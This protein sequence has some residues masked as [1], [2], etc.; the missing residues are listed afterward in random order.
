[1]QATEYAAQGL[2][3]VKD[4]LNGGLDR[5]RE[6]IESYL[7]EPDSALPLQR[8]V[9]ELHQ[10]RGTLRMVQCD[11]AALLAEEMKAAVQDFFAQSA[12][13]PEAAFEAVLGAV[14]Q[15]S[16]YFD[17]LES[18]ESD[19]GLI[20][21]P[22]INELRVARGTS[23]VS[24]SAL[25]A[26]YAAQ[27]APAMA[28]V[29]LSDRDPQGGQ[30]VA[31][32]RV[33]AFNAALLPV[34]R[35]QSVHG[36]I[37]TLSNICEEMV[38]AASLPRGRQLFLVCGGLL[39][40]LRAD[41]LDL[42]NDVKRL[43]GRIGQQLKTIAEA[44]DRVMGEI[45]ETLLYSVVYYIGRATSDG[46]KVRALRDA[47]DLETLLPD[48]AELERLR[49][50]MRG[51]N[52][53]LVQRL[54]TEIKDDIELVKNSIDLVVRAGDKADVD[55]EEAVAVAER[56]SDT[57]GML[58]MDALRRVVVNQTQSIATLIN[59]GERD[60]D[61]WMDVAM[62]L[63][64]V[65]QS[66]DK[67]LFQHMYSGGEPEELETSRPV[68][69][70]STGTAA[71]YHEALANLS[72]LKMV[73]PSYISDG[74]NEALS[75]A[76][77]LVRQ[78]E[79]GLQ[80]LGED[81]A[82][83][84]LGGLR[85]FL[86]SSGMQAVRDNQGL[87]LVLADAI[88]SFEYYIEALQSD[89]A[90][91]K[92]FHNSA[93]DC[94]AELTR[95]AGE[96][97]PVIDDGAEAKAAAESASPA[98]AAPPDDVDPE[99]REIFIEEA[100]EV[101]ETLEE[102][103]PLWSKKPE[104]AVRLT[105]IR[106]GFHTLKGSGRMVGAQGIGEFAWSVEYL[107]NRCLEGAREIDEPVT[108]LVAD[109]VALLPDL[110]EDFSAGRGS[111]GIADIMR[112]ADGLSG[113]EP[114]EAAAASPAEPEAPVDDKAA[115]ADQPTTGEPDD[116]LLEIFRADAVRHVET[117]R[118][119]A[120]QAVPGSVSAEVA[121]ALHTLKGSA[122]AVGAE[123]FASLAGELE[124]F[125]DVS[126][127]TG[128]AVSD[129]ARAVLGQAC[130]LFSGSIQ[131]EGD[132]LQD[133]PP[134]D[135]DALGSRV[136]AL[137]EPLEQAAAEDGDHE[138]MLVFTEE[139]CDIVDAMDTAIGQW[140]AAP[141]SDDVPRQM[142]VHTHKLKGSAHTAEADAMA[143][144]AE[145]LEDHAS[146]FAG[147]HRQAT[148]FDIDRVAQVVEGLYGML[149][150]YRTG[151]GPSDPLSLIALLQYPEPEQPAA[152]A[153]EDTTEPADLV[154]DAPDD[155][156][157]APTVADDEPVDP[158]LVEIFV[159]EATDL[160]ELMEGQL[161]AWTANPEDD[162]PR[163]ELMRLLHTLKGSARMAQVV[164]MGDLAHDMETWIGDA[165]TPAQ[166]SDD[167]LATRIRNA[168]DQM[169]EQ[170]DLVQAGQAESAAA[171]PPAADESRVEAEDAA[172][173]EKPADV[174]TEGAQTQ[175]AAPRPMR[176]GPVPTEFDARLFWED[177]T[178][179]AESG[180]SQET[181]RVAVEQL[182]NMLNQ[183][184]EISIFRTRLEQQNTNIQQHL[185][186][187]SQTAMRLR[188]QL[189]KLDLETEAQILA[190]Q[191]ALVDRYKDDFDPLEMD[192]YSTLNE[193][194]R[195]LAEG[196]T[197]LMSIHGSMST[198]AETGESLLVHQ[199]RVNTSL[200]QAL[201]STLMVP[202]SRQ[203]QRLERILR[204]TS[205]EYGRKA[206]IDFSG[207]EAELDRNV[208][209]RMV[210]P[211][212]H[213]LRNAVIHG[214]EAPAERKAAGKP[215]TGHIQVRLYREGT[216]LVIELADDGRGLDTGRIREKA[217]E[218]GML[219]ANSQVDDTSLASLIFEP[220]FSTADKLTQAAGRGVG[221]DV[222]NAEIKQ[223]GGS[224][225]VDSRPGKGASFSIRLPLTLAISQALLVRVGRED[226]AIPL[227][228]IEG[229]TRVPRASMAEHLTA[230]KPSFE[231]GG[232]TYLMRNLG[233][234]LNVQSSDMEE[235]EGPRNLPVLLVRIGE[236]RS[237][238]VVDSMFGSREVVVKSLG[239]QVSTVR[240]ISG[241]TIM[242]DGQVVLILDIT[243]LMQ[244]QARRAMSA[245]Q[246]DAA[247]PRAP[248]QV[249]DSP[250]AMVVDDSIT[251]RRVSERFLTRN[252]FRVMT[253]KDGMD[254]LAKLQSMVPD[255]M[256]LDIE[257]PRIDGFELATYMR[258]S[259]TLRDTPIVMITS[260][261]GDK[262][263]RRAEEIGVDRFLTK[264]YQEQD[265]LDNIRSV[266]D[267]RSEAAS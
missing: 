61:A 147:G 81:D 153:T 254:A 64:R 132:G 13:A 48:Q 148:E 118:A 91:P 122:R 222:V 2:H 54:S 232:Q 86:A 32:E 168:A 233:G 190:R 42:D 165:Q 243:A 174:S 146:L 189:R 151:S 216:Q 111:N 191:E 207:V 201:M 206:G 258:N 112:R 50:R 176:E 210:A 105:E 124:A 177:T 108:G 193:L 239:P 154:P 198:L 173:D 1:M 181:A 12:P 62:A 7:E 125:A 219:K 30:T 202:F 178:E 93:R 28:P 76:A 39:E 94:L 95:Q 16:D 75:E 234:L 220:G 133:L 119:F 250:L 205:Q 261:G 26:Q 196:V 267:Q 257:M 195:S 104:D 224:L 221:L 256:L 55:L 73:V 82:L 59:A 161:S 260:R 259:E 237:A 100:G 187:L 137:R 167:T 236:R 53:E 97:R 63:L 120:A 29:D 78:V 264:P 175:P 209:E 155:T 101:R 34:L 203:V 41:G 266:L 229:V 43:L 70:I 150:R 263:R 109:A 98:A 15:L 77:S 121:R 33:Q 69:D 45:P 58:G 144:V 204:Q 149:D 183:A 36:H 140:R 197:D 152:A 74:D 218:R 88:A 248:E 223:L 87:V 249:D 131:A 199:G 8:S 52:T 116:Q 85:E 226:Y 89:Q 252:G 96:M 51:P 37:D 230:E 200:Q 19:N 253:A 25:F 102:L 22:L 225:G 56:V 115:T 31:R 156:V 251:I 158:E 160:L 107:L 21:L 72:R 83:D 126:R 35:G 4:E 9:V 215:E 92:D 71:I 162:G 141:A 84:I 192:R 246:A 17:L 49:S 103:V 211:L 123:R 145:A 99:I 186:E 134:A 130:E 80:I 57:L 188:E 113:R 60:I 38:E 214:L 14:V 262:H 242:A 169:A 11:G 182:D 170:L 27:L 235:D 127:E 110:I 68:H 240:G 212:E 138:L 10:I 117:V 3:W 114:A 129:D 159:A 18:G 66:L 65:E 143:E 5:V 179:R 213:L 6:F 135:F 46:P 47:Y 24:E 171:E 184:G 106:R 244:I 128:A 139:A 241:A 265:L 23:V 20:F 238:F 79:A 142:L 247:E 166:R 255:V 227:G 194:S 136:A 44:G 231:Y 217:V 163:A 185:R 228:S 67:A 164:S 172:A 90:L 157:A 40:A 208:L 180:A 245:P